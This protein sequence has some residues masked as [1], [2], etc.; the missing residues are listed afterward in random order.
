MAQPSKEHYLISD[1]PK[2][3][4]FNSESYPKSQRSIG[5]K[6]VGKYISLEKLKINEITELPWFFTQF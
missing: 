3:L 6:I 1:L 5:L 2:P 4:M